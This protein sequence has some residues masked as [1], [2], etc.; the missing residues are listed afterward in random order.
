MTMIS[1]VKRGIK[2][3]I[4]GESISGGVVALILSIV[5]AGVVYTFV[6]LLGITS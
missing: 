1:R 3:T 5:T 4:D 2:R 6:A